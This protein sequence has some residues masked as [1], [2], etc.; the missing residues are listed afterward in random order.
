MVVD[1]TKI[2]REGQLSVGIEQLSVKNA[3]LLSNYSL[4]LRGALIQAP[5]EV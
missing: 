2:G 1:G 3:R 5:L 4:M